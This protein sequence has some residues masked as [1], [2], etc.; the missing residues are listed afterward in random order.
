V[1]VQRGF[2]TLRETAGEEMI[3]VL[4]DGFFA[5]RAWRRSGSVKESKAEFATQ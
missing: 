3:P 4:V 2:K 1:V 5:E